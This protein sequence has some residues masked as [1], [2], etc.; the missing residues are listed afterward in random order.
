MNE[1]GL[2]VEMMWLADAVYP[3]SDKRPAV[4]VLE[5]IQYNLDNY[6]KTDEVVANAEKIRINSDIKLH[7]LIN[8]REGNTA[9]IEFIDGKLVVHRDKDLPVPTL[10]NDTYDRSIDFAKHTAPAKAPSGRSL[11]RFVR[12][13]EKTKAYSAKPRGEKESVDYAFEIL[14]NAS[15]PNYTQW[16]IVYDQKRSKIYFKTLQSPAIKTLDLKEFDFACGSDVKMLDINTKLTGD[17]T[18]QLVPY[19]RAANRD[20]IERS[21]NGTD[22]L[23]KIPPFVRNLLAEYPEEFRCTG[24]SA[25]PISFPAVF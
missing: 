17:V 22:F 23:K 10:T 19:T 12:A 16:S 11:D 14:D 2:V 7:Y 3:R 15:Q 8:D 13:S 5:W 6:S 24:G 1:A 21:F 4:D 25:A 20:L 18:K 9:T